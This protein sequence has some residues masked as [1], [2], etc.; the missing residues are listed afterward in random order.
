MLHV[1]QDLIIIERVVFLHDRVRL[2]LCIDHCLHSGC[3]CLCLVDG[4]V[5]RTVCS[6]QSCIDCQLSHE[7]IGIKLDLL[8]IALLARLD[9][10]LSLDLGVL[11]L[12]LIL[13]GQCQGTQLEE[14]DFVPRLL[15]HLFSEIFAHLV[16]NVGSPGE[17][18]VRS[19]LG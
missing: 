9:D 10:V 2:S 7:H 13:V 17:E 8:S 1:H 12:L 15:E 19:V 18:I 4:L 11:D 3:S 16:L 5:A 14:A 6:F